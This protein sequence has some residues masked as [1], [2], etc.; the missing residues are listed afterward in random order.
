M[1]AEAQTANRRS[2]ESEEKEWIVSTADA[3]V[4]QGATKKSAFV[5]MVEEYNILFEEKT[6]HHATPDWMSGTYYR[7]TEERRPKQPKA[8]PVTAPVGGLHL[9]DGFDLDSQFI[10][11]YVAVSGGCRIRGAKDKEALDALTTKLANE[12]IKPQEMAVWQRKSAEAKTI[13]DLK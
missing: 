7:L 6:G 3:K 13:L 1:N 4:A 12:G 10:L 5:E 11:A 8:E 2:L 9:N